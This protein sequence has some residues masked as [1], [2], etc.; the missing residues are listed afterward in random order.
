VKVADRF[1]SCLRQPGQLAAR[2]GGDEFIILVPQ[3]TETDEVTQLADAILCSLAT[4]IDIDGH[5]LTVSASVGVMEE[6]VANTSALDLM[7]GAEAALV[8]AKEAG[9]N[10]WAVYAP[11]R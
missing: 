10:R 3:P 4:P 5:P 1:R 11:E 7:K 2:V 9:R 8:W 6:Q